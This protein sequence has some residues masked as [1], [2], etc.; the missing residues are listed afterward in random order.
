MT[1]DGIDHVVLTSR[2]TNTMAV[3]V[4]SFSLTVS[5]HR[6]RVKCCSRRHSHSSP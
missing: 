6:R 2:T 1:F 3:V 5:P 4:L